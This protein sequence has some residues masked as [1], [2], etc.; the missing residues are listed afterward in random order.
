MLDL[1]IIITS[2]CHRSVWL[3]DVFNNM[4]SKLLSSHIWD[5]CNTRIISIFLMKTVY[6]LKT[7][8]SYYHSYYGI[9]TSYVLYYIYT[10]LPRISME[11][12]FFHYHVRLVTSRDEQ[13][14]DSNVS[15]LLSFLFGS[16]N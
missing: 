8:K 12:V 14:E 16:V 7:Y 6:N 2:Y 15:T 9:N 1:I 4:C 10:R 5:T 3:H 11:P 13:M